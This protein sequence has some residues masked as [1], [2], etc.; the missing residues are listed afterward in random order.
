M[1]IPQ[2]VGIRP[3]VD[4]HD[5]FRPLAV[6]VNLNITNL[7]DVRHAIPFPSLSS[8]YAHSSKRI[9]VSIKHYNAAR[10]AAL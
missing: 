1:R 5:G 4:H 7:P 9:A 2:P 6:Q 8:V 3:A 10:M